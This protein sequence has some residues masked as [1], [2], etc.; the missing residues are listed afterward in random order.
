MWADISYSP[1]NGRSNEVADPSAPR[2]QL[3]MVVPERTEEKILDKWER[4]Q[5]ASYYIAKKT[6][7]IPSSSSHRFKKVL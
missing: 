2:N 1:W 6:V 7:N 5:V 4:L 3:N